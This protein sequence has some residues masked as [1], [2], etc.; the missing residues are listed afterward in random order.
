[1][2]KNPTLD[3]GVTFL[4]LSGVSRADPDSDILPENQE[5]FLKTPKKN[6]NMLKYPLKPWSSPLKPRK[7]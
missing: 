3:L 1:M 2:F 5:Q 7:L 4:G 6:R